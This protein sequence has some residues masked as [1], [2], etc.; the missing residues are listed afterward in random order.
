MTKFLITVLAAVTLTQPAL[1]VAVDK[2]TDS[3]SKPSSFVPHPHS[4]SHVYGAPIGPAAVGHARTSHHKQ[5]P[6]K[7]S[8]KTASRDTP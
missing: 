7:R 3:R 5:T 6:K 8:S 1:S 2:S 4:N